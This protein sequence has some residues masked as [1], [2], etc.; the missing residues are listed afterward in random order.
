MAIDPLAHI[1]YFTGWGGKGWERL[2]SFAIHNFLGERLDGQRI[3]DI[4]TRDGRACCLFALLGGMSTGIDIRHEY[5]PIA[6]AEARKW[7]IEAETE[8]I[9]FDGNLDIFQDETFDVIFT[10]SV[11]VLF[12]ELEEFLLKI[13]AKLKSGGKIVFLENAY[14]NL[15]M[16]ALRYVKHPRWD[17]SKTSYFTQ[18]EILA[19]R[20]IF[21]IRI[22]K[23][24]L[25]PPVY[26]I[27]G[28]KKT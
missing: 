4:G 11:L 17:Y 27:C 20:R 18:R 3:L 23:K 1:D 21:D 25:W 12:V 22:V 9:I 5:L 24:S 2:F 16:C 19:L 7:D 15:I 14:G 28:Y 8:F 10:K 26:L 6:Q 13:S